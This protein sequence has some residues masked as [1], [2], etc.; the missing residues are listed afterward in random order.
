MIIKYIRTAIRNL[1]NNKLYTFI[2]TI[3]LT[4]GFTCFIIIYLWVQDERSFGKTEKNGKDIFQLTITHKNGTLDPNVPYSVPYA[5]ANIYPE[6]KNYTRIYRLGKIVNCVFKHQTESEDPVMFYEDNIIMVD[7][8]FFSIFPFPF[9]YGN[10]KSALLNRDGVVLKK[11]ISEKYFGNEDPTGKILLLNNDNSLTVTGVVDIPSKSVQQPDFILPLKSNLATDYNWRDP[12]FILL[13]KNS[14]LKAFKEKISGSLIDLYPSPISNE[15]TLGILPVSKSYLSFGRMKYIYILSVVAL[16]ILL[17]GCMNYIILTTGRSTRRVKEIGVRKIIGAKRIQLIF[18]LLTESFLFAFLALFLSLILVEFILPGLGR[19]IE[20]DLHIGYFNRPQIILFF[21]IVSLVVGGLAGIYP[22]LIFTNK[23]PIAALQAS[24]FVRSRKSIFM[25]STVIAQFTISFILLASTI[26]IIKQLSFMLNQPLGFKTENI[27]DISINASL[28]SRFESYKDKLKSN[29]NILR[30][31]AGQSVPYNED[32]KTSLDWEGKNPEHVPI[33]R[34]SIT[35]PEYIETFEMELIKGRSFSDDLRTDASN[36][37]IN[38]KAVKLLDVENPLGKKL[39][40]WGRE[41]E[42]IGVVKDFHHVSLHREILPHVFTIHP[43]NYNGLKHIFIKIS[44]V[45]IPGTLKE[46]ESITREFA[47]DYPFKY[48]FIDSGIKELYK[49]DK[50]LGTIITLFAFISIFISCLGIFSLSTFMAEQ[51]TNEFGIRKVNG[52]RTIHLLYLL[53]I[54]LFKWIGISFLIATP[55]AFYAMHRWLQDFAF[56][57]PVGGWIFIL[58]GAIVLFI[59]F[60]TV[61]GVTLNSV[62]KN[63]VDS[64]RFE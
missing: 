5:M 12:S 29:P 1:I 32:Y 17:V 46:I 16:S 34:Y 64:L 58:T 20:K 2:N 59:A 62:R 50:S 26:L 36:Y 63:P 28:V 55:L 42:I 43:A 53:N 24:H 61:S 49:T 33:V 21:L 57:V 19:F 54:D 60:S 7:T 39:T 10:P 4:I 9:V 15:L 11:S 3:S 47:P 13:H 52:A 38:E 27:I 22:A 23:S 37:I 35:L 44:S 30:I 18:Q 41:G 14:A 8:G 31:T 25:I 45:D 56:R 51:R 6:I 48:S 40:F